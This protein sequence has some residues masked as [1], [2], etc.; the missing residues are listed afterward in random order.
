M[1]DKLHLALQFIVFAVILTASA[2][3]RFMPLVL[4]AGFGLILVTVQNLEVKK[5][6]KKKN[7]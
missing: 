3:E 2:V 7:Q 1:V 5:W 4:I 6:K